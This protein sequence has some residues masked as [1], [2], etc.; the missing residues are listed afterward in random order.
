MPL[1]GLLYFVVNARAPK[2]TERHAELTLDHVKVFNFKSTLFAY[3]L[4]VHVCVHTALYIKTVVGIVAWQP[5]LYI[6]KHI[7][8]RGD[9]EVHVAR[10]GR[11]ATTTK[12]VTRPLMCICHAYIPL[13]C[14]V[15][16]CSVYR[17]V[18]RITFEVR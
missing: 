10:V 14:I 4:S 15:C 5:K 7:G 13:Y 6:S 11:L 18:C 17:N 8:G 1:V 12:I 9:H 2:T 16:A 3:R